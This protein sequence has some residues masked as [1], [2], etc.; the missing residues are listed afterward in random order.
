[1]GPPV[2]VLGDGSGSGGDDLDGE[3]EFEEDGENNF[4]L[5][6][7]PRPSFLPKVRPAAGVA[8]PGAQRARLAP[9]RALARFP[10]LRHL[11][12]PPIR[13]LVLC[14]LHPA[15]L[16]RLLGRDVREGHTREQ[17]RLAEA[18]PSPPTLPA[19]YVLTLSRCRS[20]AGKTPAL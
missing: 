9:P 4:S 11:R 7:P 16:Q 18:R 1:M 14:L 15:R 8:S 5:P 2:Q 20:L 12:S 6:S 10:T 17:Q 19:A 13:S 3:E